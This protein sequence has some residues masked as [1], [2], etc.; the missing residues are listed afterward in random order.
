MGEVLGASERGREVR[1]LF[2]FVKK[3]GETQPISSRWPVEVSSGRV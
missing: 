1:T 3:E 2:G